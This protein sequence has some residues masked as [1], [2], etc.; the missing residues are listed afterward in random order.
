MI[1]YPDEVLAR[2]HK[3]ESG[4]ASNASQAAT[5][6][7]LSLLH[8]MNRGY[9]GILDFRWPG[10][11]WPLYMRCGS[12]DLDNFVQLFVNREYGF[13]LP[14]VPDRILDLGAYCGY[15]AVFLAHRFP[16]AEIVCIEPSMANFQ[17]LTLN[18]AAYT[19]IRRLNVV[20]WA[21]TA[22]VSVADTSGGY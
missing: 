8:E 7:Y 16:N 18:T 1:S 9:S 17:M 4:F 12:S 19:R 11:P 15:A 6:E 5:Q 20:V 21:R 22:E 10:V 14:F 13:P 3:I 2:K